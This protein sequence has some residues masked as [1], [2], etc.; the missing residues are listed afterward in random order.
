MPRLPR[1]APIGI[2]QHIIQ[3]GNN[4]QPCFAEAHDYGVFKISSNQIRSSDTP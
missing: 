4:R 1:F 3:R 2:P